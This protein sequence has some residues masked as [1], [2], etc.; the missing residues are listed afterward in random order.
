MVG[1]AALR[2]AVRFARDQLGIGPVLYH[3]R[4]PRSVA[5][6]T[7]GTATYRG[8]G[9]SSDSSTSLPTAP[10]SVQSRTRCRSSSATHRDDEV[11]V[12]ARRRGR[13]GVAQLIERRWDVFLLG[14]RS[15]GGRH[16]RQEPTAMTPFRLTGLE[17]ARLRSRRDLAQS[18]MTWTL[19]LNSTVAP[20]RGT[21][22]VV[23][24]LIGARHCRRRS[25]PRP[26]LS[27]R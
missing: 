14:E 18:W 13:A 12:Q 5:R 11:R 9:R 10:L 21:R 3:S 24:V 19:S 8:L 6:R 20:P 23:T 16:R 27:E 7:G 15:R 26:R 17:P 25:R 2:Q 4:V 22:D 1:R